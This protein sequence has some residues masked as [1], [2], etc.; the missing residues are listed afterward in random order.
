MWND[1]SKEWQKTFELAWIAF[2]NGSIP[3][4]AMITDRSGNMI[5]AG[6]NETFERIS[7]IHNDGTLPYVY[8]HN[9]DGRHPQIT[10]GCKR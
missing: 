8:G 7:L 4:G 1:L 5:I 6:R 9:C 3:I 2:Q 10:C